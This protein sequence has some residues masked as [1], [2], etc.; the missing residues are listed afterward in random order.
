MK[1][2]VVFNFILTAIIVPQ[3]VV[4][5]GGPAVEMS[6]L[7]PDQIPNTN[8]ENPA[9]GDANATE[10]ASESQV[11]ENNKSKSSLFAFFPT[12]SERA[13]ISSVIS[14]IVLFGSVALVVGVA[15]FAYKYYRKTQEIN[16]MLG[17]QA[18][19]SDLDET[20]KT[21]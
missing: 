14:V 10:S 17:I 2:V 11:S 7:A 6:S 3:L 19:G 12:A 15:F 1:K 21:E 13:T 16:Q 4:A 9:A 20:T 8:I 18:D 5:G